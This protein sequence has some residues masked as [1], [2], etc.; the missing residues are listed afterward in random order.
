MFKPITSLFAL[1][2]I[3]VSQLTAQQP[4]PQAQPLPSTGRVKIRKFTGLKFATLSPVDSAT[5]RVGDDVPLRLVDPLVVNGVTVARQGEI[6][7]ASVVKVKTPEPKCRNGAVEFKLSQITFSD[8]STAKV[9]IWKVSPNPDEVVPARLKA[10]TNSEGMFL[11][12]DNW[13]E[14]ALA[15]PWNTI[16]MAIVSPVLALV[17]VAY[18]FE[19]GKAPACSGPGNNY[20]LP[21]GATVAVMV[22]QKHHVRY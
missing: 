8:A 2:I 13:Y 22:A 9:K 6:V 11:P 1:A 16:A 21:A 15:L 12:A 18:I 17:G 19:L 10:E 4:A 3:A 7:H 5:S 14:F 20:V